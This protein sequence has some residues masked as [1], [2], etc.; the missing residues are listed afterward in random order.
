MMKPKRKK[1]TGMQ[2]EIALLTSEMATIRG[3]LL[4]VIGI[5]PSFDITDPKVLPYGLKAHTRSICWIVE[6]VV[7]QQ[8][9]FNAKKLGLSYETRPC[10][11]H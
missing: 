9:K 11:E 3:V 5:I 1:K 7:T 8:T 4:A 2:K 10:P 6:Q